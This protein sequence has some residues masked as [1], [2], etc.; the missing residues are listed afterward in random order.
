MVPTTRQQ[1]AQLPESSP[2]IRGLYTDATTNASSQVLVAVAPIVPPSRQLARQ[3]HWIALDCV[4]GLVAME[5]QKQA[6]HPAR[7]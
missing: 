6:V 3:S 5:Q 1:V 4:S 2:G 7:D